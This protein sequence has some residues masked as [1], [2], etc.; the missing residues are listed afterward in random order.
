MCQHVRDVF[1][2]AQVPVDFEVI[3]GSGENFL[4][5]SMT[6]IKRNRIAIKGN[7]Q[8]V[9]EEDGFIAPNVLLRTKLDLFV[10]VIHYK[11]YPNVKATI[12]H[13]NLIIIR[14][15]TEGEYA[16]LEHETVSGVVESMKIMTK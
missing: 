5:E 1:N 11:S 2:T 10:Y 14:Q 8:N 15:N 13:L 3:E 6:S 16:M 12:P 9:I 4:E 7:L